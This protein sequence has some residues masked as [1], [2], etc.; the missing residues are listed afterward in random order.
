[1]P[2]PCSL[3][4]TH[5]TWWRHDG[6]DVLADTN[7]TPAGA[8]ALAE[9]AENCWQAI[10]AQDAKGFGHFFRMSFEAQVAMFPHMMTDDV[11]RLIAQYK[12]SAL[13]WKLSGAGGGGYLILVSDKPIENAVRVVARRDC[14]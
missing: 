10:L 12:D 13:G 8:Q 4:K 2:G 5:C 14:C 3:W 6:F 11:A 9:A 7:I 1:M